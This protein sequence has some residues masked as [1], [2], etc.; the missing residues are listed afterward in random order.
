[1][2]QRL[3][4]CAWWCVG[5]AAITIAIAGYFAQRTL[6]FV[7]RS[8]TA[9]GTVEE[10]LEHRVNGRTIEDPFVSFVTADGR[11]VQF[12]A[13]ARDP[14]P[15]R[16]ARVRVRYDPAKPF[17]ARIDGVLELWGLPLGF[18]G[19]GAFFGSIGGG[20]LL[21]SM[22]RRRRRDRL[23]RDGD[24]VEATLLRVEVNAAFS[25]NGR[26]PWRLV[27]Q[28]LNPATDEVHVFH[29]E[30]LWFDPTEFTRDRRTVSVFLDRT[31]PRRYLVD[32]SFLPKLAA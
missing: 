7:T 27:A 23:R 11:R 16:G 15:T 21:G 31:H 2:E 22:I 20:I 12:L 24:R 17:E 25:F 28:W 19:T 4:E 29:S 3:R 14:T 5:F 26:H 30:N 6:P 13:V 32:V 1:M 10:L 9:E 18:G 8:A